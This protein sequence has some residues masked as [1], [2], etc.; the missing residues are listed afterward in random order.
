[1][2]QQ[3]DDGGKLIQR[4]TAGILHI[5][6]GVDADIIKTQCVQ[7]TG[8]GS[9]VPDTDHVS[10][11]FSALFM[12]CGDHTADGGIVGHGQ[13]RDKISSVIDCINGFNG[14]AIHDLG[15]GQHGHIGKPGFQ[16]PNG[17]KTLANDHGCSNLYHIDKIT[18]ISSHLK[19]GSGINKINSQLKFHDE[20]L[21][22]FRKCKI[23]KYCEFAS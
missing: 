7:L 18:N 9:N 17:S 23:G 20:H 21:L 4:I 5:F 8:A 15:I 6:G 14:S 1:M 3:G 22:W 16:R 2:F 11:G 12:G 10:H 19:G 13:H